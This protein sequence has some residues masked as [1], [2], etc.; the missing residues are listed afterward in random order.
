MAALPIF[1]E[2]AG[3][4]ASTMIAGLAGLDLP[5]ITKVQFED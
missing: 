2:H 5:E 1:E 3:G 4:G